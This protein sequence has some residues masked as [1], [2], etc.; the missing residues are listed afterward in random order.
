LRVRPPSRA[1][2][3]HREGVCASE[4]SVHRLWAFGVSR[5]LKSGL[6]GFLSISGCLNPGCLGPGSYHEPARRRAGQNFPVPGNRDTGVSRYPYFRF[7]GTLVFGTRPDSIPTPEGRG[8]VCVRLAAASA[9]FPGSGLY[10]FRVSVVADFRDCILSGVLAFHS[11][12]QHLRLRLLDAVMLVVPGENPACP[13]P[14]F[15]GISLSW[16]R[17]SGAS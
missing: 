5:L 2:H 13:K 9:W 16:F 8:R 7:S 17:E 3:R 12:R 4:S 1:L 11:Q 14:V 10:W 6:S 15:S